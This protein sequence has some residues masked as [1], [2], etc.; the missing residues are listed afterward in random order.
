MQTISCV[1]CAYNEERRIRTILSAVVGHPL[2]AE[3]IVVNDGSTDETHA[4]LA[5]YGDKIKLISY[6]QNRGKTHALT[7]GLG[8]ASSEL[9]M[10]LDADLKGVMPENISALAEP[11]LTGR[12]DVSL[13]L[14]ANS[15]SAYRLLGI[16]FV[17]GERVIP[18][19]LVAGLLEHMRKLPRF[20]CESFI[21]REII[22]NRLSIT[23]VDWQNV[24]NVRMYEK[25]GWRRGFQA[26]A[27]M[28][29]DVFTVLSPFEVISQ[30]IGML[31]LMRRA[32]A[33]RSLATS[34]AAPSVSPD[35]V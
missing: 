23:V 19:S 5:S 13:S 30:H 8:A 29:I 17:S 31:R 12:S 10:L 9:V 6:P 22:K 14:R 25:I 21:N 15:L 3:V 28:I 26:E 33:P 11:I 7:L 1:I 34:L 24:F 35:I 2:L 16:D 18:R 20:G 27:G 32:A 4:L